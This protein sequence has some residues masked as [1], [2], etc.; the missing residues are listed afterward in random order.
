LLQGKQAIHYTNLIEEGEIETSGG[1]NQESSVARAGDTRWGY[2]FRTLSSLMTLY[3]VI[4]GVLEEVQNDKAFAKHGET[5]YLLDL[6]QS[7]DFVFMLHLMVEILGITNSLN[8]ALQ[9]H[10]QDLLN[11]LSLVKDSKDELQ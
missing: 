8:V 11:A 3:G 2:H 10:D 5:I 6:L 1:L 9:R 7:F 4:I